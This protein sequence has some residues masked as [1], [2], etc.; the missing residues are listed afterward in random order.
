MPV[1]TILR[2]FAKSPIQPLQQHIAKVNECCRQLV[3]F[4]EHVAQRNWDKAEQIRT[5]IGNLEKEAD[6]LKREIRLKTPQGLF[7]PINRSDLLGVVTQ[8]DK[9]ANKAKDIAGLMVG[10]AMIW[11]ST[12]T[13]I[14]MVYLHRCLDATTQAEAAIK[15]LDELIETGFRG[16]E[17]DIVTRMIQQLDAIE[18]DTD[19]MQIALRQELYAVEDCYN[20]VDVV[21]LYKILEL[22]GDLADQ[23]ERVGSRL[24]L[25]LAR[26]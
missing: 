7:L 3:P 20:P 23:A 5:V 10:R 21:F 13:E 1:N 18:D 6:V 25:M 8:Q 15:E 12:M 26:S 24:E 16:R 2:L 22:V 19:T 14:F 11:P 17:V 4:F 9:I